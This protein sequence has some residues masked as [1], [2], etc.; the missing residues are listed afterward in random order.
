MPDPA[1][2]GLNSSQM[3]FLYIA[4]RLLIS[5][6]VMLLAPLCGTG[7]GAEPKQ[8]PAG[9]PAAK[10][11]SFSGKVV[12]TMD[13]A[14]YT[15]VLVDTGKAKLWAAAPKFNVK[16]GDVVTVAD[17]MPMANYQ[18]KT[19]KR[20]FD[21]VY[22]SGAISSAGKAL[23]S[24][25]PPLPAGHPGIGN[26]AKPPALELT[27]IKRA[28][29]GQTVAEIYAGK[30]KLAGKPISVRGRVVKYNAMIMGKNWL[31]LRDGSGAEGSNDLV[32]TT[33]ATAK[34]GDLVLASGVLTLNRDFGSGYSFDLIVEDAKVVP[35]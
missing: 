4:M 34:V 31:H 35:E 6:G 26:E 14:T 16:A 9:A 24:A 11:D 28:E 17:A 18:S 33:T 32:I 30:G 8:V 3:F 23:T 10:L 13:A 21:V 7:L 27:G 1:G 19:L 29:G 5:I 2:A 22:F 25:L 15:Y 12:E 20:T